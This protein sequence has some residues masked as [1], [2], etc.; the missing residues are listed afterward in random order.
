MGMLKSPASHQTQK[1][2]VWNGTLCS[3]DCS[4][5][6]QADTLKS[7]IRTRA[8]GM[9][10]IF[11]EGFQIHAHCIVAA[12][13]GLNCHVAHWICHPLTSTC[14]TPVCFLQYGLLAA[15]LV[16]NSNKRKRNLW[17]DTSLPLLRD[18]YEHISLAQTVFVQILQS[19]KLYLHFQSR[20]IINSTTVF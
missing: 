11:T 4:L 7:V 1:T 8:V 9:S 5:L 13:V 20:K 17:K 10:P 2:R 6:T 15:K 14:N 3:G 18:T 19:L 12:I 16:K